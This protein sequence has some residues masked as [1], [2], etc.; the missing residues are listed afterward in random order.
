MRL[1]ASLV[2]TECG[3]FVGGRSSVEREPRA[4]GLC[5]SGPSL[6]AVDRP[7]CPVGCRHSS[8]VERLIC[9]QQVGSSILS[10]GSGSTPTV[11]G[12]IRRSSPRPER[13]RLADEGFVAVPG[14]PTGSTRWRVQHGRRVEKEL[15][16]GNGRP[17]PRKRPDR[18]KVPLPPTR[19]KFSEC[20]AAL[21]A[22]KPGL[23]FLRALS[24]SARLS[25][26]HVDSAVP[27]DRRE[28]RDRSRALSSN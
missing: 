12:P 23:D 13:R 25:L 1:V 14:R 5:P 7:F 24:K 22:C 19:E 16:D 2:R 17:H 8:A 21:S 28:R 11:A 20:F 9:N 3:T 27:D 10:G 18:T 4:A 15:Q 26:S 6:Y